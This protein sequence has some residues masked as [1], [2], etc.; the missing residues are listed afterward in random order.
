MPPPQPPVPNRPPP[1]NGPLNRVLTLNPGEAAPLALAALHAFFLFA[2]YFAMRPLREELS[3]QDADN[4]ELL[5]FGTFLGTLV[6]MPLYSVAVARFSRR[7][8]LPLF[9]G[10]L[11]WNI[12]MFYLAHRVLPEG[13]RIWVERAFYVWISVFNMFVI[14]NLW[15]LMADVFV[16]QRAK[17]L[18]GP[19]AAACTVGALAGSG[20]HRALVEPFGRPQMLL[21]GL[22]LFVVAALFMQRL[23]TWT[24]RE[25]GLD[26]DGERAI[27]GSLLSGLTAVVRSPYLTGIC[28]YLLAHTFTQTVLYFEL[29]HGV[30]E[31]IPDRTER[32][33]LYA[34][35][36]LW[37]NGFTLLFQ[38]LLV[39]RI[40]GWLGL[41]VTLLALPLVRTGVFVYLGF[42]ST[43]GVVIVLQIVSKCASYGL[44]KPARE[45]LFTVL[46][47]EVKYRTKA[48]I[49]TVV[50]RGADV[51][52]GFVS[53]AMQTHLAVQTIA[54][55]TAPAALGWSAL[56]Y[57]LGRSCEEQSATLS[58]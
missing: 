2:A 19:I 34:E 40:I 57:R 18:F 49:D 29:S 16:S 23:A 46:P 4:L 12:V 27:G 10:F 14:A 47:R 25:S 44:G 48:F 6:A 21:V 55:V 54:F 20:V 50:Y 9:N 5:W 1:K 7:W 38:T 26:D 30:K 39:G 31:G 35:I 58:D 28:V 8:F 51:V 33:E 15:S 41:G 45:V 11:A 22:L 56:A 52:W 36:D 24:A 43:L 42:D 32:S 3:A 37:V 13:S 17:R 53:D